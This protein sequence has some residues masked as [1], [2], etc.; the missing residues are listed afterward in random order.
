MESND[1]TNNCFKASARNTC[2]YSNV[3][4]RCDFW[5]HV[6]VGKSPSIDMAVPGKKKI[7]LWP[8]YSILLGEGISS[9][10]KSTFFLLVSCNSSRSSCQNSYTVVVANLFHR[11]DSWVWYPNISN[12]APVTVNFN[13]SNIWR[14]FECLRL[15]S[16]VM[17]VNLQ[18]CISFTPHTY[19]NC[20]QNYTG[21]HLLHARH[22]FTILF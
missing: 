10:N 15:C 7:K 1:W 5:L 8:V 19:E 13:S 6:C 14:W 2:Q 9:N 18:I 3:S 20:K 22:F 21:L 12:R 16:I 17:I 11:L 4:W